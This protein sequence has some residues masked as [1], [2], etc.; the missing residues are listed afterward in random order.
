V[1]SL[2]T[3]KLCRGS[4]LKKAP[5]PPFPSRPLNAG[6]GASAWKGTTSR[7][8]VAVA[9]PACLPWVSTGHVRFPHCWQYRRNSRR[10]MT[11]PSTRIYRCFKKEPYNDIPNDA[12]W[13]VLRKRLHLKAYKLSIIQH[14]ER[15]IVCTPLSVNA[16]VTLATQ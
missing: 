4:T 5:P 11:P 2:S 9:W 16:F 1:V 6:N 12:V 13:R 8:T 10:V 7:V 15:W 14:L 3:S